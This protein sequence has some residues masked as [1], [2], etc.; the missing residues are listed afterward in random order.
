MWSQDEEEV[1]PEAGKEPE[2][3]NQKEP[4]EEEKQEAGEQT[5]EEQQA[6]E[7]PNEEGAD[8]APEV[9]FYPRT[10]FSWMQ[11]TVFSNT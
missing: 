4:S 11:Y 5:A 1:P 7:K 9:D 10:L 2:E 3:Q 8:A 6:E